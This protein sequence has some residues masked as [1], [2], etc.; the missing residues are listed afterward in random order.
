[1]N[2]GNTPAYQVTYRTAAD[3]LPHPLRDDFEFPLPTVVP[4]RSVSTIGPR[5]HKIISAIV[6]KIYSDPEALQIKIGIGQRIY[7]WGEVS[8][9]DAFGIDRRLRFSQS[10]MWMAED[11]IMAYDTTH[12]NE[13]N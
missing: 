7:M 10:L 5:H 8:H 12:Y 11:K 1:M 13:E 9:K 4:T 3:V 2:D 6:P